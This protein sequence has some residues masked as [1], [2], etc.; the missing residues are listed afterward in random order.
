MSVFFCRC[1][2]RM[3][4][5]VWG[6]CS[7]GVWPLLPACLHTVAFGVYSAY[8]ILLL[9]LQVP[10]KWKLS[11]SFHWDLE[12]M[13]CLTVGQV[14]RMCLLPSPTAYVYLTLIIPLSACFLQSDEQFAY[15]Q[16]TSTNYPI[17]FYLAFITQVRL[18]S[19][20]WILSNLASCPRFTHW[21]SIQFNLHSDARVVSD[22]DDCV[23]YRIHPL[24]VRHTSV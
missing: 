21:R 6:V 14:M 10:C 24:V 9:L 16:L 13:L 2:V 5:S 22:P 3:S 8:A 19:L 12:S 23:V 1:P 4:S 15:A 20:Y 7:A 18:L 11:Y 17:R